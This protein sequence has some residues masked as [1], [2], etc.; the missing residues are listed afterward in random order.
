LLIAVGV[1]G[2]GEV[3][4]LDEA[5]ETVA[6]DGRVPL[7]GKPPGATRPQGDLA[8]NDLRKEGDHLDLAS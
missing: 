2:V 5:T 6:V 4:V 8:P 7:G 1:V 3:A